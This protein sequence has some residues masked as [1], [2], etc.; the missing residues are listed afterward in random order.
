MQNIIY[1]HGL[2]FNKY[3]FPFVF[4]KYYNIPYPQSLKTTIDS[5]RVYIQDIL[6]VSCLLLLQWLFFS[7]ASISTKYITTYWFHPALI[8]WHGHRARHGLY[9]LIATIT[10]N[11]SE[12]HTRLWT[13]RFQ[14]YNLILLCEPQVLPGSSPIAFRYVHFSYVNPFIDQLQ[15]TLQYY[16]PF[17]I[18]VN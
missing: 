6:S 8:H 10:C 13:M 15:S 2:V 14:F 7:M 9:M 16:V 18:D 11:M 5:L 12:S 3:F 1:N 17:I 4:L